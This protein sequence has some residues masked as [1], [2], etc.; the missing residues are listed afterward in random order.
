MVPLVASNWVRPPQ[1]ERSQKS[2]ERILDAAEEV[3]EEL[4]FER[5]TVAEIVR[6][7]KSSVGVFY[8]RFRDKDALLGCLHQRS[9]RQSAMLTDAVLDPERWQG[10]SVAKILSESIPYLV[11]VFR[12][13]AGLFRVFIERAGKDEKFAQA[14]LVLHEYMSKRLSVLLLA[15]RD[16]IRHPDPE[17]A[18]DFGLRLVLDKLGHIT[19]FRE[20]E[21]PSAEAVEAE[22]GRELARVFIC[23]LGVEPP[24]YDPKA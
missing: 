1:Q 17:L 24:G 16:E 10:A 5:A 3:I 15:R 23:Y 7:A 22:L 20:V 2:L 18:V 21:G 13:K 11:H 12:Q 14:A 6:R 4:G 9:L 19:F 8:A